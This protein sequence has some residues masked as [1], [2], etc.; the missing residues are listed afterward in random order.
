MVLRFDEIFSYWI[1]TWFLVYILFYSYLSTSWK[2]RINPISAIGLG[3]IENITVLLIILI[4]KH[5]S[6]TFFKFLTAVIILKGIPF[7]IVSK[8]KYN[9]ISSLKTTFFIFI[10]YNIY[11]WNFSKYNA[12]QLYQFTIDS[13][14]ND[15]NTTPGYHLLMSIK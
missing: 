5:F 10:L 3:I 6:M 1:F 12:I 2:L 14:V 15:K 9:F 8:F 4:K 7:Y 11:L 13:I